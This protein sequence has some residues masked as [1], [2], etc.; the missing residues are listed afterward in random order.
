[1][2]ANTNLQLCVGE[3][4]EKEVGIGVCVTELPPV[5]VVPGG[6]GICV[7]RTTKAALV[8]FLNISVVV[9]LLNKGSF[10]MI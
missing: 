5:V 3:S 10:L 2:N 1:M 4:L 9:H 7:H 6:V 8:S